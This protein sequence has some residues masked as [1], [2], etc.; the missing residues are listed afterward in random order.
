MTQPLPPI[1]A[2][3]AHRL[4][5]NQGRYT[6]VN[7]AGRWH[8]VEGWD[9]AGRLLYLAP[10]GCTA[11]SSPD[12]EAVNAAVARDN[13]R[14]ALEELADAWAIA[15]LLRERLERAGSMG[16]RQ[17]AYLNQFQQCLICADRY[18]RRL[19]ALLPAEMTRDQ[20]PVE[21]DEV[22]P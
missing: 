6:L 10:D 4:R 12:A 17:D 2:L 21:R 18:L 15:D 16:P 3:A 22:T 14:D 13:T 8:E 1:R 7:V 20:Y 19:R 5:A 11:W 9:D